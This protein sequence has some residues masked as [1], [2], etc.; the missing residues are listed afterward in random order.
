VGEWNLPTE[1][2]IFLVDDKGV[3]Q[4]RF[5]GAV[6]VPELAEAVRQ[7]LQVAPTR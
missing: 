7:D 1:P 2:W 3:I 4:G 6:S 5:E